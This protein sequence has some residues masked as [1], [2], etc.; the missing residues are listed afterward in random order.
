MSSIKITSSIGIFKANYVYQSILSPER[1]SLC[2]T[3][4][5]IVFIQL[6]LSRGLVLFYFFFFSRQCLEINQF[7]RLSELDILLI[8]NS[9]QKKYHILINELQMETFFKNFI[10]RLFPLLI[11]VSR[12]N[13]SIIIHLS[14]LV[15]NSSSIYQFD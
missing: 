12:V 9:R 1:D 8:L 13:I 11:R 14:C 2:I 6:L 15:S 3:S 5:F 10:K 4:M 7:Q